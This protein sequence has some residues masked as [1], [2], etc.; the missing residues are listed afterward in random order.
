[1]G[2]PYCTF[3]GKIYDRPVLGRL[4]GRTWINDKLEV[5]VLGRK[6]EKQVRESGKR[7]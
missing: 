1:M 7:L 3:E 2:P 4:E 5:K 6:R